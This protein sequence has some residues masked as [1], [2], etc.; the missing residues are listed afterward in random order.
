MVSMRPFINL[1]STKTIHWSSQSKHWRLSCNGST[2]YYFHPTGTVY[3]LMIM[4]SCHSIENP[5]L[6]YFNN[7]KFQ[8]ATNSR[9]MAF[10]RN[11]NFPLSLQVVREHLPFKLF[12]SFKIDFM[13]YKQCNIYITKL[14]FWLH[15]CVSSTPSPKK[16]GFKC[17]YQ[18][19][20]HGCNLIHPIFI[21]RITRSC[22]KP[23]LV[24]CKCKHFLEYVN[25]HGRC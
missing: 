24:L 4:L 19:Y 3:M 13:I 9:Q 1:G 18:E 14:L 2:T 16:E 11:V 21:Q 6:T 15:K 23:M 22:V 7:M 25:N 17:F 10:V 5:A 12:F 8:I 20:S